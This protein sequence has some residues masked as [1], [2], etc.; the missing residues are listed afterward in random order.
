MPC[1]QNET[2]KLRHVSLRCLGPA[3]LS[4]TRVHCRP[5]GAQRSET[6]FEAIPFSFESVA[7]PAS[8]WRERAPLIE[9]S[10]VCGHSQS[11]LHFSVVGKCRLAK[12]PNLC[13]YI[14]ELCIS[15]VWA[16]FL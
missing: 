2:S 14:Y 16:G 10:W 6:S 11:W 8:L 9:C 7:S 12:M 15:K 1:S 3:A 5:S 4:I 13:F